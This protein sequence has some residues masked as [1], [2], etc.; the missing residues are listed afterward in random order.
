[1]YRLL[2]FLLTLLSLFFSLSLTS[3]RSLDDLRK[4]LAGRDL[5]QL[6]LFG[7]HQVDLSQLEK[8]E[9]SG[10][11]ISDFQN[12]L[13]R[14]HI[15]DYL[16]YG[17]PTI[18]NLLKRSSNYLYIIKKIFNEQGIPLDLAYLPLIESGFNPKAVS[19]AF[20]V[21]LWQFMYGTGKMYGLKAD[22]WA[23]ERMDVFRATK[24]AAYHLKYLYKAFGSWPMV[25][26]A[27]NAGAGKI[28]RGIK[29]YKT[30]DFW[31]LSS[32]GYLK[33]ETINYVPKFIAITTIVKNAAQYGFSVYEDK[34]WEE[35]VPYEV[36]DATDINLLASSAEMTGDDFRRFNAAVR[37]FATPPERSFTV[38]IPRSRYE[39]FVQTMEKIPPE[40]RVTFRRYFVKIGDNLTRISERFS[41]P[42]NPI[43]T[44]N[45]FSS[46]NDIRAGEYII[47]PIKGENKIVRKKSSNSGSQGV[48][49]S[50]MKDDDA[51]QKLARESST[52]E[53]QRQ[54][55][56]V[57]K[58]TEQT[59]QRVLKAQVIDKEVINKRKKSSRQTDRGKT[60][61]AK[62]NVDE[63]QDEEDFPKVH[64]F[65]YLVKPD[66]TLYLI[67]LRYGLSL[68]QIMKWNNLSHPRYLREGHFIYLQK[69]I[70]KNENTSN[71]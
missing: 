33:R 31:K 2:A 68:E 11:A 12:D 67:A 64:E 27:Y 21:G 5:I 52:Q 24:A 22:Y 26:A 19:P 8:V 54:E 46:L 1:M 70:V 38:Y 71:N 63:L 10:F 32:T 39:G 14:K 9:L 49:K 65:F 18:E 55:D 35:L 16:L 57:A 51:S 59:N 13:V 53:E 37:R 47:V 6:E 50:R 48:V 20:A 34:V 15:R 69:I 61:E 40:E 45:K 60:A 29:R 28:E 3:C 62:K 66:D 58:K 23:D 4:G 36:A 30:K 41:I 17:R 7:D 44:I 25:L 56:D 43:V 42:I